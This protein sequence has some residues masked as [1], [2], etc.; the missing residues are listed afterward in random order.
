MTVGLGAGDLARSEVLRA[1]PE[2]ALQN[3]ATRARQREFEAGAVIVREGEEGRSL[4]VLVSGVARAVHPSDDGSAE[5][6]L[7][8]MRPG[9]VFGELAVLDP[10]T[11]SASVLA[12]SACRTIEVAAADLE[13]T[14]DSYPGTARRMLGALARSLTYAREEVQRHNLLLEERVADRTREVRETQLEVLRRL[15]Q[16]VEMRDAETGSHILR[17]S[18]YAEALARAIG[19]TPAECDLVLNAAP[20]HDIGKIGVPDAVLLKPGALSGEEWAIMQSHTVVGARMLEGSTSRLI[21]EAGRIAL[22]HHERWDGE[23]YPNGVA[24]E[25]IPLSARICSISDVFDALTSER[26][27]KD[28][29]PVER[30]VE[31]IEAQRGKMFDPVLVDVFK[32][33]LPELLELREQPGGQ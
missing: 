7:R 21:Q 2:D 9:E 22:N 18:R 17:M 15:G 16:A 8:T 26:P 1:L 32:D 30:A 20:M 12:V 31:E 33:A 28:E 11:R 25:D 6:A 23:G 3:L 5:V 14:F 13:R 10:A 27:Y 19:L 24:G 4:H 29:W